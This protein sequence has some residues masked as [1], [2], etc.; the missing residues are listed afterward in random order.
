[1]KRKIV[2]EEAVRRR[3]KKKKIKEW[4]RSRLVGLGLFG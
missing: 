2:V 1:M 4:R 3:L